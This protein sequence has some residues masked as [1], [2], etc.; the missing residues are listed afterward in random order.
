LT[1]YRYAKWNFYT[2]QIMLVETVSK[3]IRNW[4]LELYQIFKNWKAR[5]CLQ[6]HLAPEMANGKWQFTSVW[7]WVCLDLCCLCF[8]VTGWI[9]LIDLSF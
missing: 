5:D 2:L 6:P 7:I 9:E 4:D 1:P 8:L 3:G